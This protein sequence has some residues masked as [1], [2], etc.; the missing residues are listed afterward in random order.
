MILPSPNRIIETVMRRRRG[1]TPEP[2]QPSPL[3]LTTI[4][5]QAGSS[6]S[7]NHGDIVEIIFASNQLALLELSDDLTFCGGCLRAGQ[8]M[9]K[10]EAHD[11][12]CKVARVLSAID[13]FGAKKAVR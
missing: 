11:Q 2:K 12:L 6:D 3:P 4:E 5:I 13:R 10:A 7:F 8:D 1:T 9:L